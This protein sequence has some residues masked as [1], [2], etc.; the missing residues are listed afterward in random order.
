[1][2]G[3]S[4]I[5]TLPN[6]HS[7]KNTNVVNP[8]NNMS[9]NQVNPDGKKNNIVKTYNTNYNPNIGDVVSQTNTT[10][11]S[12]ES[13]NQIVNGIQKA[14]VNNLTQLPSRNISQNADHITQDPQIQANYVPKD[15]VDYISQQ[16][17]YQNLN[18]IPQQKEVEQDT[19]DNLYND[20]QIPIL[21]MV[22]F[23]LFQMPFFKKKLNLYLPSLFLKNG[24]TKLSGYVFNTLLFG[25][26][27][28]GIDKFTKYMSIVE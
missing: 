14:S 7:G 26:V 1:M 5:N 27:F 24:T 10:E 12:K 16:E 22:L 23:F 4:M 17:N 15:T 11:L 20:L 3:T 28:Y 18:Q 25:I 6:E 8:G 2:E 19:L 9:S 21:V 13:I